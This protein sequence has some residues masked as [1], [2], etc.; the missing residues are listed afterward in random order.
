MSG[1][2]DRKRIA[3][4]KKREAKEKKRA[5]KLLASKEAVRRL[6]ATFADAT[7]PTTLVALDVEA[8][9]RN[10]KLILEIGLALF[11]L[12]ARQFECRHLIIAENSGCR[13]GRFVADNRDHFLFGTSEVVKQR[14]AVRIVSDAFGPCLRACL[15]RRR[16]CLHRHRCRLSVRSSITRCLRLPPRPRALAAV[17]APLGLRRRHGH[18]PRPRTCLPTPTHI[19]AISSEHPPHSCFLAGR[20]HWIVGHAFGGDLAWLDSIGVDTGGRAALAKVGTH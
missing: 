4:E 19:D 10:Q 7:R 15:Q 11:S 5:A 6:T 12:P 18:P 13:N 2:D 3:K 20:A 1:R 16:P 17:S 14:E 9:E 8:F